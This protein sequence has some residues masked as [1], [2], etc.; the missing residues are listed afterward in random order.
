MSNLLNYLN[1]K[2]TIIGILAGAIYS[3]LI[4]FG[5]VPDNPMVWTLIVGWTGIS[6]RLALPK[7]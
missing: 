6:Y 1:G 5:V 3:V 2:K 4:T 7:K